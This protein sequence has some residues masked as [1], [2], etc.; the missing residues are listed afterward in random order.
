MSIIELKKDEETIYKVTK[1][2]PEF[3]LNQTKIFK[4]KNDALIQ[5]NEWLE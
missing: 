4:N 3:Y 1:K 2:V 5:F